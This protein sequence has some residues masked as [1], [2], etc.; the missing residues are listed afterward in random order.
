MSITTKEAARLMRDP[1]YFTS[2]VF[3]QMDW[4]KYTKIGPLEA[5]M[6]R[7]VAL[8]PKRSGVLGWR[9]FGKTY[10][11]TTPIPLWDLYRDPE[12]KILILSKT[13]P[14]AEK[15]LR[16]MRQIISR[17]DFLRFLA[18]KPNTRERKWEDNEQAFD[19]G[20]AE[21]SRTPSVA[22]QGIDGSITGKRASRVIADDIESPE[23]TKTL[24]AR[25]DLYGKTSELTFICTYGE[26]RI[27]YI[28]TLHHE[29]DSLYPKKAKDGFQFR[30][31]PL[32]HPKTTE[33]TINL[34]P[35]YQQLAKDNNAKPGDI[36]APYRITDEF[37]A[38]AKAEGYRTFAMQCMLTINLGETNR[39]PLRLRDLI[40]FPCKGRTAPF[41]VAWG[42]NNG[43]GQSTAYDVPTDA[44]DVADGFYRPIMFDKQW[45]PFPVTKMWIDPSG[46][47]A[48][49]SGWAITSMLN[50]MVYLRAAGTDQRGHSSDA[51]EFFA[52]TAK[53]YRVTKIHIEDFALQSMFKQV[54]EPIIREHFIEPND[55]A[56]PFDTNGWRCKCEMTKPKNPSAM[57]ETRMIQALEPVATTHRLVIDEDI[58]RDSEFQRQWTR[59][60]EQRNC[61]EHE[62]MLDAIANAVQL[63]EDKL[64]RT[65]ADAEKRRRDEHMKK[66][67][68]KY[69]GKPA[70]DRVWFQHR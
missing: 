23:N 60:C 9:G 4:L 26:K 29:T 68:E 3:K 12:N 48:D 32:L 19:V 63:W 13:G 41:S 65:S 2:E 25:N 69:V 55:P 38:N 51:M 7:Y 18:P 58:A 44:I 50:G 1:V 31:Y 52:K 39:Y 57:K 35:V 10:L 16:L 8:G 40:V 34:A 37:V 20:P 47:G 59:L 5:D 17:V 61:L 62:D 54:L 46:A 15:T 14:D 45:L 56:N 67:I 6:I 33:K 49:G 28:G 30:S 11:I 64:T 43:Q 66:L 24:G 42:T 22:S 36:A 70:T 27:N 21:P 53:Q